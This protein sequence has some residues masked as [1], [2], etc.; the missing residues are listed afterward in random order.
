MQDLKRRRDGVKINLIQRRSECPT[1]LQ[2][3]QM[4]CAKEM[5]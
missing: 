3:E 2:P 1:K 5:N 4:I